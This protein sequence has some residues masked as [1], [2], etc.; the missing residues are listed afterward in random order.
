MQLEKEKKEKRERERCRALAQRIAEE[1]NPASAAL[2]GEQMPLLTKALHRAGVEAEEWTESSEA[3]LLV[4]AD[5]AWETLPETLP[6]RVL[7]VSDESTVMAGWAEQLAQRGY[8]RDFGWRSKGR[9]PQS[10]LFCTSQPTQLKMV[11]DTL[12][13]AAAQKIHRAHAEPAPHASIEGLDAYFDKVINVDQSPI[14]RTPRSNPATYTGLFTHIRDLMADMPMAKERGYGP[15]RFSFNVTQSAGGGRCEACQGDGLVKVEMHFLPDVYVPCDICHGL[16]YNRETLEV[17]YKGKNIAQIL[18]M[19][20]EEAYAFM[21]AQP[22]IAR[23]LQ[24]LLDVG[25]SYIRLG[26]SATTLSGGEAQRVKLAQELSRTDTGKTLYILDEPTTGLHFADIALL[27][28]VLHKLRDAGNTIV[29][30]EHNLDVIKTADWL[31]DMGPEGG[32]G[33]G[34]VVAQGTPEA[35]AAHPQS[36]TG[37]YLRQ[38]LQRN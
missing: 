1:A 29:I 9:A 38:I 37:R 34:T 23:K 4:V 16:R 19:T 30:I 21:S 33:G 22:A 13:T 11:N 7:L 31:I 5:P 36:H 35:V 14:G 2:R 28:K 6:A 12:Y 3:E 25:L 20:V 24:T 18:D 15:G 32:S 26:Q 27:L 8:F 17:L 10:A